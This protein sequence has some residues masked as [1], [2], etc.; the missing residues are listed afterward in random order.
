MSQG[1][2]RR[3]VAQPIPP[4]PLGKGG[5]ELGWRKGGRG[6]GAVVGKITEYV[7]IKLAFHFSYFLKF[8]DEKPAF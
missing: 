3:G 4:P 7:S 8:R 1:D 5:G 2:M 6:R